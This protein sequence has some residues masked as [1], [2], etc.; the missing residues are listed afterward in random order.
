[1]SRAVGSTTTSQAT[2]AEEWRACAALLAGT[3]KVRIGTP[4]RGS[5]QYL[6]RNERNLTDTL[7]QAPA[8]VRVYGPDGACAALC[9]DLDASLGDVDTDER[10]LVAWLVECGARVVTDRAP[11]GGRHVYVP[12]AERLGH[13]EAREIVEALAKKF[14]TID[15]GPHRSLT[16]GCIRPPGARHKSGGHQRLTMSLSAAYD[17]LRRRNGA[18]VVQALQVRLRPQIAAWRAAQTLTAVPAPPRP[19]A[20]ESQA[21]GELPDGARRGLSRRIHL[22]AREAT[23]D[24]S[25]Y[26]T[27]SEAR[28]AVLCAAAAAGWQL[29]DVVA[30][31]ETGRWPGLASL[32][33]RYRAG[34]RT[35]LSRDWLRACAF[36]ADTTWRGATSAQISVPGEAG[37]P[38]VRRSNTSAPEPHGGQGEVPPRTLP[39]ED[40]HAFIRTWRAALRTTE[41]HRLPGRRWYVG[42]F[43][44]RALGEAAHKTGDRVVAFGVRSLAVATGVD[45]TTVAA[46]LHQLADAG[47][48]D[49]LEEGRGAEADTWVLTLPTDLQQ[50]AGV[51]RWDRGKAHAL[52]PAFREL[53]VVSALVFEAV[54]QQRA[55]TTTDLVAVTG[56]SR[57]AVHEAVTI[58]EAWDLL[59]RDDHGALIAHPG[60]LLAVAEHLDV[61][62]A[63]VAQIAR[64][65]AQRAAW[66]AILEARST[67]HAPEWTDP[68]YWEPDQD[69][70]PWWP[71]DAPPAEWTLLDLAEHVQAA[72]S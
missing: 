72:A 52:R 26:S 44:L 20:G 51:L 63:V 56:I 11:T 70:D 66:H 32:Y 67:L 42:R 43:V 13:A 48:I 33:Q 59:T 27:G 7:P 38:T 9:L 54:E 23:W 34:S 12:L 46:A 29:A 25:R 68:D 36:T 65:R 10:R 6:S 49:R 61:L 39:A 57:S 14:R 24:P 62:D 8:A 16:T 31:V 58:L 69:D 64:Y 40:E 45:H 5:V 1:M 15:P 35:A 2:P 41:T 22:I 28:F 47:W 37:N 21:T 3:P 19:A 60:R 50:S 18:D 55:S 30:R 17:V 71:D 53:G 4:R